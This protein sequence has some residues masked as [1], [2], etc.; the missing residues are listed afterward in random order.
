[1]SWQAVGEVEPPLNFQTPCILHLQPPMGSTKPHPS[2]RFLAKVVFCK[3][4]HK[5]VHFL[6]ENSKK[7]IIPPLDP[8]LFL[9]NWQSALSALVHMHNAPQ[10]SHFLL[11]H[12]T[13]L[14]KQLK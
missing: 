3:K 6:L 1:M 8:V 12:A 4:M 11:K 7:K 5:T 10:T 14:F 13:N 9:V 2:S